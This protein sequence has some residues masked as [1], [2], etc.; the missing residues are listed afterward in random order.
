MKRPPLVHDRADWFAQRDSGIGGSDSGALLG[1]NPYRTAYDVWLSKRGLAAAPESTG[2]LRRGSDLEPLLQA[3]CIAEMPGG[4]EFIFAPSFNLTFGLRHADHPCLIAT[5]DGMAMHPE[6]VGTGIAELKTMGPGAFR[7]LLRDGLPLSY[8]VQVQQYLAV[9]EAD[10]AVVVVLDVDSWEL[11][12]IP[13]ERDEFTIGRILATVPAWWREYVEAGVEPPLFSEPATVESATATPTGDA[14]IVYDDQKLIDLA[15]AYCDADEEADALRAVADEAKATLLASLREGDRH[16]L[17][18]VTVTR[19]T[20]TRK[21]GLDEK[22]LLAA[23]VNPD[24]YRKP[25]TTYTSAT[26]TRRETA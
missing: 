6:R 2:R 9:C 8:M 26:I 4:F 17:G 16:I 12:A 7:K 18:P 19:K 15:T 21:G 22:R 20:A 13:V 24:D 10:W 23:G 3:R 14:P 25:A 1:V 11:V 5:P